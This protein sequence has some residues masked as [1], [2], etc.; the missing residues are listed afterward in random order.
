MALDEAALAA[1]RRLVARCLERDADAWEDFVRLQHPALEGAVRFTF[2]RCLSAV[3]EADVANVVQDLY[4]RL[5]ENE[6]RRLRSWEG[7]CPLG[8]W[9]K[10]LAV[11]HTLNTLRDERRRGRFGGPRLDELPLEPAAPSPDETVDREEIARV[12]RLLDRL[13]PLQRSAVRM[14]YEDGLSYRQI[15]AALAISVQTVGS[16]VS[17]GRD[18]L[19][20]LLKID[21]KNSRSPVSEE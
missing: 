16:L 10:S 18:R 15:A 21:L 9:L 3:P 11:R 5:Y 13:S 4:A 14:F 6:F 1:E 19:R 20:E 2:L 8:L 12:T 17:R 7:R